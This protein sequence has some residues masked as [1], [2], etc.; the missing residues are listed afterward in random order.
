MDE[1]QQLPPFDPEGRLLPAPQTFLEKHGISPLLFGILVLIAVFF[2][3]QLIGGLIAY[4]LVGAT[5]TAQ[6]VTGF[7]ITTGIS[8]IV[9]LLVPTLLLVRLATF[10]PMDYLRIRRPDVRALLLPVVGIFSLQQMLQIYLIFQEK[11]PVPEQVQS[12]LQ[13]YKHLIEEAYGMLVGTN[14]VSELLFVI[15]VIALI[16]AVVEEVLFRGLVQ[17]SFENALG[18]TR[19]LLLTG[20]IFGAYHLNPF[21]LV[22]L[23]ALGIYLGFLAMRANSLW[24]SMAAHFY[25]NA[26]A[27]VAIYLQQ[28]DDA[29]VTGNPHEMS[30]GLLLGTFWFF[31]VLFLLSTYYFVHVTR[32][33]ADVP[34]SAS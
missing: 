31:G 27:C 11:I 7:R 20:V 29:I 10:T 14:S 4:V 22:P 2:S 25:N 26:M 18:S 34:G 32:P 24:V 1:P 6:N 13:S 21:S 17:R 5:P 9:F 15:F 3:Y 30:L 12:A 16:P 23:V 33:A 28:D 19:G 8:Q